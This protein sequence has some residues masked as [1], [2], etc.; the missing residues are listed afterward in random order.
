VC[1]LGQEEREYRLK[2]KRT[3]ITNIAQRLDRRV[4]GA[5]APRGGFTTVELI[6]VVVILGIVS[7]TA[8]TMFTGSSEYRLD[9]A[10]RKI[11]SDIRYAQQLAM[12]NHGSYRISFDTSSDSYTLYAKDSN[13]TPATDPFTGTAF[14]VQLDS[15]VYSGVTLTEAVF[16][17]RS[18]VVFDEEG[19]PSSTGTIAISAGRMKRSIT[20]LDTGLARIATMVEFVEN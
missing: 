7:A 16:G 1:A 4:T 13:T 17:S 5:F 19:D 6:S 12:D 18:Y 9:A 8:L 10:A 3:L 2:T 20:L 11:V 14:T 15:D